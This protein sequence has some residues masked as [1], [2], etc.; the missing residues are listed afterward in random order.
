MADGESVSVW[1]ALRERLDFARFTPTPLPDIERADLRKRDGTPY[2][3]LKNPRADGGAGSY[4]RLEPTDVELYELMDGRRNIQEIL[5]EHLQRK[6]V[7]ALDRLGRLTAALGTNGFF[8]EE[9]PPVYEK[10]FAR[11]ARRVLLTRLSLMLR[12]LIVWD[13]AR[14]SNADRPVD[15]VYRAIGWIFFT[16]I[17][18]GA[19]IGFSAFGLWVWLEEV[20]SP[21][22]QLVTLNGSYLLGI[23]AL[24]VLQVLSISVHEAGH[25]LA[26]RHFGRRVRRLGVAIYYLFPCFYVDSTDM[27][28]ATRRQR[29]VVSLAGPLGGVSVGAACALVAASAPE[30]TV[31]AIAFKAASLFVFQF[32]LNLLPILD[33]DGY[34]VLTDA[35][36]APLLR[37]R[38]MGFVRRG[39]VRK[40]RRRER[41]S[42]GEI[43]LALYGGAAIVVSLVTLVLSLLLWETRM[44]L[45][46][47]ELGDL[48][49]VG[50]IVLGIIVLV[51]VGPLLVALV[52]RVAGIGRTFVGAYSVRKRHAARA[53]LQERIATLARYRFFAGMTRPALAA[54]ADHIQ[55]ETAAAG[56]VVVTYGEAA[57]RFYLVRSGRLEA[58]G[59]EGEVLGRIIPG[60]GFGELALLDNTTRRATVRA[61]EPSVLWS[62]DRGHF[63]RWV[64]DRYEVAARIRASGDEREALR[65]FPF[66]GSLNRQELERIAARLR[67]DRFPAGATVFMAGDPGD[68]YYLIREGAAEVRLADGQQAPDLGPGAAFGE[69]ALLFGKPRSATITAKTDLVTASLSRAD[70][71]ALVRASGETMGQFKSRTAHYVGAGLGQ[72]VGSSG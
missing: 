71:A 61:V 4:V 54:I 45:A 18:A 19:L 51:F 22:H 36:D 38:A 26:I 28:L 65:K 57:D 42:R 39:A 66:F 5:V 11:R 14:W 58:V 7:F 29:V 16:R 12:R 69:L 49:P 67:T 41:W 9:R 2:T 70:F 60:E 40:L 21:R 50:F 3:V 6:N 1:E 32:G 46:T 23:L 35:L 8:G 30:T 24:I 52:T 53:T 68:R 31:G 17:G 43:G 10:L 37:Q 56:K 33:L 55:E 34:H 13:V 44:K 25:A 20:R 27:T 64:R 48:G 15:V 63:G 59:P 62:L 72:T 47:K